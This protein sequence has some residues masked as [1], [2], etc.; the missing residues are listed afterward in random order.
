M[1]YIINKLQQSIMTIIHYS[2]IIPHHNIPHLLDRCL[3][4]IPIREDVQIIV[5]DD[6]SDTLFLKKVKALEEQYPTAMFIY[7]SEN[8]GGGKARNIGMSYA[9]GQYIIFADADDFFSDNFSDVLDAYQTATEDIIYFRN[10]SVLSDNRTI[11]L[12]ESK[13]IDRIFDNFILTPDFNE[14]ICN[15]YTPWAKFFRRSFILEHNIVFDETPIAN[16][17]IFVVS[18]GCLAKTRIVVQEA[19]YFYTK[20]HD[21]ITDSFSNKPEGLRIRTEVCFRAQKIMIKYG[22]HIRCMPLST[23]MHR[24]YLHDRPLYYEYLRRSSEV[25]RSIWEV[26]FQIRCLEN[27]YTAKILLYLRSFFGLIFR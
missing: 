15:I 1:S 20:R 26:L 7:S 21:S 11:F 13:W 18:A 9:V 25:Y 12:E 3:Q 22:Y 24:A 6:C 27:G 19:I 14:I 5:V 17:V 16:D 8:G 2:I 23:F 10:Y 4:S